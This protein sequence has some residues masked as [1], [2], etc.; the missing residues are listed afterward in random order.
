MGTNHYFQK[1]PCPCCG[2]A[3]EPI[4]LGKSSFGWTYAL[5]I[6][7]ECE[8]RTLND[9]VKWLKDELGQFKSPQQY[10][11]RIADEYGSTLSL[12]EWLGVVTGRGV[13]RGWPDNWWDQGVAGRSWYTSEEDFHR[14]NHSERGPNGLLRR[15]VNGEYCIGHGEGTWDYCVG[16][17]S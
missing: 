13:D 14:K 15:R 8:V 3:P 2:H 12:D 10:W 16:E 11:P 7:P 6:R 17:F 9:L 4:H 5:H 1:G